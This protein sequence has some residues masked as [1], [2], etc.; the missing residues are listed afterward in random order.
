MGSPQGLVAFLGASFFVLA[1]CPFFVPP[2]QER[3]TARQGFPWR[4]YLLTVPSQATVKF[5]SSPFEHHLDAVGVEW[6]SPLVEMTS[7]GELE[8]DTA[9]AH[10]LPGLGAGLDPISCRGQPHRS[11]PSVRLLPTGVLLWH[12]RRRRLRRLYR[13]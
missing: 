11:V 5:L 12:Y 10:T 2:A 6:L 13:R 1:R 9:Q 3:P 4:A 8:A 7:L